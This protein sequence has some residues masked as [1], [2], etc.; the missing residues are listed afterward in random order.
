MSDFLSRRMVQAL[1]ITRQFKLQRTLLREDDFSAWHRVLKEVG[2]VGFYNSDYLAGASQRHKHMQLLPLD[3]L[4]ENRMRS[5]Q[6]DAEYVCCT[7][8]L[9]YS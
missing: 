9:C 7:A 6:R 5:G 3:V 8:S 4:W 2:A 1:L